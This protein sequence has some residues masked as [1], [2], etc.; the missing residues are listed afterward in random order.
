V[1]GW[2]SPGPEAAAQDWDR[3]EQFGNDNRENP[4]A[5]TW[6]A[7]EFIAHEKSVSWYG[8]LAG[9]ALVIAALM[10]LITHDWVSVAVVVVA[11][12][13]LGVYGARKPRQL[14]YQI[15]NRGISIGH[16]RYGYDE[17][18]SFAVLPEGAFSSI[19]FMPLRRFA[20]P[21]TIYYAPE[22]EDRIATLLAGQLPYDELHRQDVIDRLM[23]LIRF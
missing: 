6:T 14:Q 17:F 11:A 1:K 21:V 20:P 15:D 2:Y 4:Q 18:R 19:T 3:Q 16:K 9:V 10:F 7:S 12:V 23:H 13:M 22:D 8:A 5:I